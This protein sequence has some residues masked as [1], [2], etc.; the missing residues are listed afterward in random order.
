MALIQSYKVLHDIE[1][2]CILKLC[3]NCT[4]RLK[5]IFVSV[6]W[7]VQWTSFL[8]I[9]TLALNDLQMALKVISRRLQCYFPFKL[10]SL[11]SS[12]SHRPLQIYPGRI[13]H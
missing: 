11:Y 12:S 2:M 3:V 5:I 10:S 6:F 8:C 7:V 1:C 9:Y 13:C 4:V